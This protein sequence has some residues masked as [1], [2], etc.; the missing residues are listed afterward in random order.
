[1]N[2]VV[3]ERRRSR[4]ALAAV[5]QWTM[6]SLAVVM[7]LLAIA[8]NAR[9]IVIWN[10]GDL[11]LGTNGD[12]SRLVVERHSA[13]ERA[14]LR[15][16]DRLDFP[17]M[18]PFA[19][20][21]VS[22]TAFAGQTADVEIDR[23]GVRRHY[24]FRVEAEPRT[25]ER[26]IS[27][28]LGSIV[29]ALVLLL[30]AVVVARRRSL[31]AVAFWLIA[32][33]AGVGAAGGLF[34]FGTGDVAIVALTV[35]YSFL[36]F[37]QMAGALWLGLRFLPPSPR[38]ALAEWIWL[39]LMAVL[40]VMSAIYNVR[41][42]LSGALPPAIIQTFFADNVISAIYFPGL[43][44]V[45]VL[46]LLRT[47]GAARARVNWFAFGV[48]LS[49]ISMGIFSIAVLS[50]SLLFSSVW[51]SA[52]VITGSLGTVAYA[53]PV[54]RHDVFGVGFAVNRAVIYS[55]VTGLLV[56]AFAAAN[57]FVGLALKSTGLALPVDLIVAGCAGLSL[58]VVQ[59][60]VTI[61]VDR[62]LF[63]RRYAAEQRLRHAARALN[64]ARD[65]QSIHDAIV[66]E[67][68]ETL[69]LHAAAFFA[70]DDDGAYRRVAERGWPAD[71][72]REMPESDRFVRF[73]LGGDGTPVVID[74]VPHPDGLPH[75]APRPRHAFPMWSRGEL[76]GIAFYSA[77][78]S[79]ALLDPQE[80]TAIERI[81]DAA[82]AAFDRVAAAALRRTQ[83][84]LAVAHAE[85]ARLTM[86][87]SP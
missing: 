66:A 81:A 35:V 39:G 9:T 4:P 11:G 62:V 1:M 17:A 27:V 19:R 72:L 3:E 26:V 49:V 79:G 60:R 70:R 21:Q 38:R 68:C 16:G 30:A 37:G 86:L 13:A 36:G 53:Y 51:S 47:R 33:G 57:W 77:H 20:N 65:E 83:E 7:A 76:V 29:A 84:E 58:N 55:I 59:R 52:A 63:R 75:G 22:F 14:G 80:V 50:P 56:G 74:Q 31:D 46:G 82:T 48:L 28:A 10:V 69:A 6:V 54:L 45:A 12:F 67:P 25:P 34:E 85:I 23:Q 41:Q 71:A 8:I 44:L 2:G 24:A 18:T 5:A 32:V 64:R 87:V 61:T 15:T 40:V 73:L 78:R 43:I 42:V